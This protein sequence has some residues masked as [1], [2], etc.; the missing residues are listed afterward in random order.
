SINGVRALTF[1]GTATWTELVADGT[2]PRSFGSSVI[3][4][5]AEDRVVVFG[6]S[7]SDF[8]NSSLTN[9]VSTLTLGGTPAWS[10]LTV[11]GTP[12]SPRAGAAAIYD[13]P[14]H[15]MIVFGGNDESGPL[16]EVWELSLG[17]VPTWTQLH[18]AGP[19]PAPRYDS[20]VAFDPARQ[21]M[22]VTCGRF[23]I[24]DGGGYDDTW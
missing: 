12:P 7:W 19:P 3:Y 11:A 22:I 13:A 10:T 1:A 23:D 8:E 15:R 14:R 4:D 6:G 16:N 24:N 5:P 21:R 9:A 18:P 20:G 17:A 2:N